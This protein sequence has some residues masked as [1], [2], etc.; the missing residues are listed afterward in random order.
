MSKTTPS[1]TKQT[2]DEKQKKQDRLAEALRA[3]LKKR[4]SQS[5]SRKLPEK[6]ETE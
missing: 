2:A 1:I 6:N 3:N 5:R 4:K